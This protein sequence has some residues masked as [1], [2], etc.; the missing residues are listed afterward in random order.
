MERNGIENILGTTLG[1]DATRDVVDTPAK[2]SSKIFELRVKTIK[3]REDPAKLVPEDA[4]QEYLT[5]E[6]S[7]KGMESLLLEVTTLEAL[8][9]LAGEKAANVN[10]LVEKCQFE[11]LIHKILK[12][13]R[14]I[15]SQCEDLNRLSFLHAKF[16]NLYPTVPEDEPHASIVYGQIKGYW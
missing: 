4:Y 9:Q 3:L 13:R 1:A 12:I 7:V 15:D 8:T 10:D 2:I 14:S 5:F 6:R 16:G 11:N